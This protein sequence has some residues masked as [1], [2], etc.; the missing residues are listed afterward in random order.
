MLAA[1][2]PGSGASSRYRAYRGYRREPGRCPRL[3]RRGPAVT[4]GVIDTVDDATDGTGLPPLAPVAGGVTDPVDD[5]LNDTLNDTGGAVGAPNL[6]NDVND[7]VNDVAN[8]LLG[9]N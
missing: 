1:T 3:H 8:G 4:G 9:G 5:A 2:F 7:T 6:G